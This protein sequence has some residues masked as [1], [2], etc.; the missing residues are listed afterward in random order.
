MVLKVVCGLVG[1][2]AGGDAKSEDWSRVTGGCD[3][4]QDE[5]GEGINIVAMI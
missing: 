5:S 4:P 3:K 2:L 1:G